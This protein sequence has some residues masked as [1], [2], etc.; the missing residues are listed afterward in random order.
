[1]AP[2]TIILKGDSRRR[3][4]LAAEAVTPGH[5]VS[6]NTSG[7]VVKHAT[8]A[9]NAAPMFA[10]ENEVFGKDLNQAYANGD[11]VIHHVVYPGSEVYALVA[12]AAGAIVVGDFLESAGDGTLRKVATAAATSQ[13][14]RASVV[15]MALQAVDN[16]GGASPARIK[17]MTL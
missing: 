13:A 9:G 7:R 6:Y 15:A 16:S 3:E 8:A 5:L 4:A 1:M 14:Q 17:V 10:V 11:N 2:N 12:A